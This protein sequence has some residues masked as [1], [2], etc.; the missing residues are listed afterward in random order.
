MKPHYLAS[1]AIV[2]QAKLLSGWRR[3]GRLNLTQRR[4]FDFLAAN[5]P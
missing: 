2:W 5:R 3:L 1:V 4:A